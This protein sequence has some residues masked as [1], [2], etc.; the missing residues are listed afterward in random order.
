MYQYEG[1]VKHKK[2][3]FLSLVT[4]FL[5]KSCMAHKDENPSCCGGHHSPIHVMIALPSLSINRCESLL[6]LLT[7]DTTDTGLQVRFH[8]F[9]FYS[10]A[11]HDTP[12]EQ[13]R[14]GDR[15]KKRFK[16]KMYNVRH[17]VD[18]EKKVLSGV[19]S[20]SL[21]LPVLQV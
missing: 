11:L 6:V 12:Y 13:Q 20:L 19:S 16:V 3:L 9:Q 17:E 2:N 8:H 15:Y 7:T 1:Q 4:Q 5:C 10:A 14:K 18:E 21:S